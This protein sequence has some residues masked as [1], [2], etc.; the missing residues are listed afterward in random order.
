MLQQPRQHL[1]VRLH[2]ALD[3]VRPHLVLHPRRRRRDQALDVEAIAVDEKAHHGHLIVRLVGDVGHDDDALL[4]DVGV[5]ARSDGVR[6]GW[7]LRGQPNEQDGA[8]EDANHGGTTAEH[9]K[10]ETCLSL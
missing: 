4:L 8:E 7:L 6:R 3:D 1:L 9:A 2:Q 10:V 5:D